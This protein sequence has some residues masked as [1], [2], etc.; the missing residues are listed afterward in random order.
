MKRLISVL[1]VSLMVIS[2]VGCSTG[3]ATAP[4]R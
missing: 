1:L 4:G 2:I 3:K